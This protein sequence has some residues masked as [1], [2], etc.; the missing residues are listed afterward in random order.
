[1]KNRFLRQIGNKYFPVGAAQDEI[2]LSPRPQTKGNTWHGVSHF[3]FIP[4]FVNANRPI[5][6]QEAAGMKSVFLGTRRFWCGVIGRCVAR[7]RTGGGRT[8]VFEKTIPQNPLLEMKSTKMGRAEA[9]AQAAFVARSLSPLA[10]SRVMGAPPVPPTLKRY[11]K[12]R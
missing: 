8:G 12:W 6:S 1:M 11:G 4:L 5:R 7:A 10:F 3:L 2:R 9:L